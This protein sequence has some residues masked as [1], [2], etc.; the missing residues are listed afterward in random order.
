[1]GLFEHWEWK[2]EIRS[3]LERDSAFIGQFSKLSVSRIVGNA[4]SWIE[5]DGEKPFDWFESKKHKPSICLETPPAEESPKAVFEAQMKFRKW[6]VTRK[7]ADTHD[8]MI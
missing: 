7:K 4:S 8:F 1:M 3:Y 2:N 6:A 5:F